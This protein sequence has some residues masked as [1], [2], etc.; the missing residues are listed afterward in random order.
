[1]NQTKLKGNTVNLVG[2]VLKVGDK[3]PDFVYVKDD[4]S[5]GKLSDHRG[6]VKVVLAVPSLD[7]GICQ[8][9]TKRFNDELSGKE[10]VKGLIVSKD[11]PFA[12]KRFC[13][14]EGVANVEIASVFRS[15][16]AD[17]YHTL[18]VDGPLQGL[19]ARVV[20]ILDEEN[21]IRYVEVV[22]DITHEPNYE[23]ALEAISNL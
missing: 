3:A 9:E 22:D 8:L 4:L 7:T 12:M 5:E 18:M 2:E 20:F 6:K 11:L 10:R 14:A 19:T 16:F 23:K 21:T 13:E 1:M 15:D 17:K